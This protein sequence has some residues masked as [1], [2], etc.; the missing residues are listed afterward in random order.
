MRNLMCTVSR[1]NA[2]LINFAQSRTQSLI[3]IFCATS[4]NFKIHVIPNLLAHGKSYEHGFMKKCDDHK[5]CAKSHTKSH[6]DQ[7][8]AHHL[9]I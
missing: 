9:R 3:L 5:L 1:K 4:Q 7:F 8:F 2:T 6:F